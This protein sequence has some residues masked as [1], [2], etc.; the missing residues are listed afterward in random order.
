MHE[1]NFRA[2]IIKRTSYNRKKNRKRV[3][4]NE[5]E[6]KCDNFL[7]HF[8]KI[9]YWEVTWSHCAGTGSCIHAYRT[10]AG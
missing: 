4:S 9:G 10:E 5:N 7:S 2:A 3:S 8:G 1:Q 6:F